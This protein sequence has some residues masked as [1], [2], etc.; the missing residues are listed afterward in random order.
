M[1]KIDAWTDYPINELGDTPNE[2]APIRECQIIDYDHNKYCTVL[3]DGVT[4]DIKSWYI[5]KEK[6]RTSWDKVKDRPVFLD[7]FGCHRTRKTT[8]YFTH[9]FLC[10]QFPV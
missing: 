7:E 3:V 2:E 1:N 10:K 5:Y 6:I 8:P 9:D 4:T